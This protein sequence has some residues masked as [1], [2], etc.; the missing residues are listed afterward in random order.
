[1][2]QERHGEEGGQ[3]DGCGGVAIAPCGV[4]RKC[5][6]A[7]VEAD[8]SEQHHG[9]RD[10]IG[11]D[12][13]GKAAPGDDG[14]NQHENQKRVEEKDGLCRREE[15]AEKAGVKRRTEGKA[16]WEAGILAAPL[17]RGD[18]CVGIEERAET[19]ELIEPVEQ[20]EPK[21]P[22]V[23]MDEQPTQLIEETRIPISARPGR[24]KRYDYEYRRNGTA[25]NFMFFQPLGN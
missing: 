4:A 8:V 13:G 19:V 2:Q 9:R 10:H 23:C 25:N 18:A 14:Q 7:G 24:V 22:V 16:G 1:M 21:R 3:L 15:R 5:E 11:L 20:D 12:G 6:V 17:A